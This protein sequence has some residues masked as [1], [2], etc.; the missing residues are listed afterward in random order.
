MT[1]YCIDVRRMSVSS[2]ILIRLVTSSKSFVFELCVTSVFTELEHNVI[3]GPAEDHL[4]ERDILAPLNTHWWPSASVCS[5][6]ALAIPLKG[7]SDVSSKVTSPHFNPTE[8][9]GNI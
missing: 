9:V 6:Y 7:C 5:I 3:Y 1:G 2:P 8:M 4:R